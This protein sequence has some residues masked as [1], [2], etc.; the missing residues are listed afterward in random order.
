MVGMAIM[1]VMPTRSS[2]G[3]S[4]GACVPYTARII[5]T[6]SWFNYRTARW[7]AWHRVNL[8]PLVEHFRKK[9]LRSSTVPM[10]TRAQKA[11]AMTDESNV[12]VN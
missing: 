12:Q 2:N 11:A 7:A 6:V 10:G 8:R 5:S 9:L 3:I 4:T 1:V